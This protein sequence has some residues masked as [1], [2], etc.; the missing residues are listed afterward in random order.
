MG[1]ATTWALEDGLRATYESYA[2]A[3][4]RDG[5]STAADEDEFYSFEDGTGP[6]AAR[7]VVVE[8]VSQVDLRIGQEVSGQPN[9]ECL[10][11]ANLSQLT[12]VAELKDRSAR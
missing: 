5:D 4:K 3:L 10:V 9:R 7:D 6:T 11:V 2:E 1:F 12:V 8:E